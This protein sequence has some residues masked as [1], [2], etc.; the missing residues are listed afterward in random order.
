MP[1][2]WASGPSG[3][4]GDPPLPA[5]V[6]SRT[7]LPSPPCVAGSSSGTVLARERG[8]KR[9]KEGGRSQHIPFPVLARCV[10][11][12]PRGAPLLLRAA[13]TACVASP[14]FRPPLVTTFVR[15]LFRCC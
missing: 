14:A 9:G 13:P 4:V 6:P 11:G 2:Q 7:A 12:C 15:A 8:T 3:R 1:L 10:S 5:P